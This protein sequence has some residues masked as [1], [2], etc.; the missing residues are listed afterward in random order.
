MTIIER[1]I[2]PYEAG[3]L[4]PVIPAGSTKSHPVDVRGQKFGKL[5][6]LYPTEQRDY[7]GSVIWHCRCD[8][9][10]E[11]DISLNKLK[12]STQISCGCVRKQKQK[13]LGDK[14]GYAAGTSAER[15]RSR[16]ARSSSR[17]G[18]RGVFMSRGRYTAIITIQNK[19]YYLGSYKDIESAV[20]V[21]K[22]A[23]ETL[24]DEFLEH[25]DR[26]KEQAD[27]DPEWGKE[28]PIRMKV[29]K[30]TGGNF[31]IEILPEMN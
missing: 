25:Y 18:I 10:N 5:T 19:E 8:C 29:K 21:R 12:H 20:Q 7:R 9:G 15:I 13:E 3:L 16:K 24:F 22:L 4:M 28:N 14:A 26:W 1:N 23:E 11:I 31:E 6:A 17:T 30:K 27:R 2:S